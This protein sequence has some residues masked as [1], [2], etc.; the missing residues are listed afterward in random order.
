M[1]TA[2]EIIISSHQSDNSNNG[3]KFEKRVTTELE[4][5]PV[6]TDVIHG[7]GIAMVREKHPDQIVQPDI[8]AKFTNLFLDKAEI[9]V[10]CTNT[11][12]NDRIRAKKFDGETLGKWKGI[13]LH[14]IIFPSADS[15]NK[16]YQ[17]P[18]DEI[19]YCE[20]MVMTQANNIGNCGLSIALM[21]TD[22]KDFFIA[23]NNHNLRKPVKGTKSLLRLAKK[24]LL[25]IRPEYREENFAK[26][27]PQYTKRCSDTKNYKE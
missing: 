14:T 19:Y 16:K 25:E 20:R 23:L 9:V 4:A 2:K 13:Y 5:I 7:K 1:P 27:Y 8:R 10:D 3:Q 17:N 15:F 24:T 11:M 22:I 12:R 26:K 21:E 18:E 6:L